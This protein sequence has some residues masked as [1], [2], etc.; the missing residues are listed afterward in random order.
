MAMPADTAAVI[1]GSAHW[2]GKGDGWAKISPMNVAMALDVGLLRPSR[3][4]GANH[5]NDRTVLAAA[6]VFCLGLIVLLYGF[7][8]ASEAL[9]SILVGTGLVLTTIGATWLAVELFA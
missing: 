3:F 8:G 6:A 9:K 5:A 4:G 2:G 7:V 1:A